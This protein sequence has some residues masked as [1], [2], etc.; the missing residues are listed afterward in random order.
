MHYLVLGLLAFVLGLVVG[1]AGTALLAATDVKP[2]ATGLITVGVVAMGIG[3]LELA[4]MR[5]NKRS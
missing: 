2:V 3:S 4:G 5:R 1:F